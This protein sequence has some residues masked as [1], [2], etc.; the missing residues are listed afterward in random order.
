[1]VILFKLKNYQDDN[2]N[3][4]VHEILTKVIPPVDRII[5]IGKASAD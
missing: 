3:I 1:M 5:I 2:N 4:L